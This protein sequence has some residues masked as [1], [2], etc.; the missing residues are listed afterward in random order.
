MSLDHSPGAPEG[1]TSRHPDSGE[2]PA[3]PVLGQESQVDGNGFASKKAP[4][5]Q[6]SPIIASLPTAEHE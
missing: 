3:V 6:P 4:V 2:N 1:V 5:Q